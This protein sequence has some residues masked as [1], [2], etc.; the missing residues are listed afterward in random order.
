V[1]YGEALFEGEY[2]GT[3]RT[4]GDIEHAETIRLY[5]E[6]SLGIKKIAEMLRR[7]SRTPLMQ[8][9]RHNRA[10]ERSGLCPFCRRIR[11]KYESEITER[12]VNA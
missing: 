1:E 3:F 11:S 2:R 5:I 10:V 6:E 9:Q 4:V 7:S 8:I 12:R